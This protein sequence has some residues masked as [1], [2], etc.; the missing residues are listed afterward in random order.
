M[1]NDCHRMIEPENMTADEIAAEVQK[2]LDDIE[3]GRFCTVEESE[4]Y[5][6]RLGRELDDKLKNLTL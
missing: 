4:A 5:L 6:E 1:D 3:N 2:G